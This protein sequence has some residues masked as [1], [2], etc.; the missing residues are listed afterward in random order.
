MAKS[1][2]RCAESPSNSEYTLCGDPFDAFDC[3]D[4]GEPHEIASHCQSITCPECCRI[5]RDVKAI[6]NPLRPR[7]ER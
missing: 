2:R 6:T 1:I 5:I 7:K 3:G 4:A